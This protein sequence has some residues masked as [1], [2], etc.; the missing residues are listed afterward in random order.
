M[1][2]NPVAEARELVLERAGERGPPSRARDPQPAG[3]AALPPISEGRFAM[4]IGM[5]GDWS[6]AAM[7]RGELIET[8]ECTE[9]VDTADERLRAGMWTCIGSPMLPARIARIGDGGAPETGSADAVGC[10]EGV[11]KSCSGEGT[12]GAGEIGVAYGDNVCSPGPTPVSTVNGGR[13]IAADDDAFVIMGGRMAFG[14]GAMLERPRA[15]L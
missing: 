4:G 1:N 9:V 8:A 15:S 13:V 3:E 5:G 10:S 11:E 6:T 12:D 14:D 2:G 7:R